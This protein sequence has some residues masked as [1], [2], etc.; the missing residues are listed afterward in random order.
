MSNHL[1]FRLRI[2]HAQTGKNSG[3]HQ[4]TYQQTGV[5][6]YQPSFATID[7]IAPYAQHQHHGAPQPRRRRG[8]NFGIIV[9]PIHHH[10][11]QQPQTYQCHYQIRSQTAPILF[12]RLSV[13]FE[14][15]L[16]QNI[17]LSSPSE[18]SPNH[19]CPDAAHT[20]KWDDLLQPPGI[21]GI[22]IPAGA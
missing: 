14:S 9:I 6:Q 8:G 19:T 2:R 5:R 13:H 15:I 3:Y 22:P 4:H 20:S 1:R 17:I 7:N 12:C 10:R 11:H 16:S 18:K 21:S